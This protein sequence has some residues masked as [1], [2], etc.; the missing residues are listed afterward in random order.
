MDVVRQVL[1][2]FDLKNEVTKVDELIDGILGVSGVSS[3]QSLTAKE[4]WNLYNVSA[5]PDK[6]LAPLMR[7]FQD[8]ADEEYYK[9]TEP[10]VVLQPGESDLDYRPD[11]HTGLENVAFALQDVLL[12]GFGGQT[13]HVERLMRRLHEQPPEGE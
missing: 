9:D 6:F 3:T 4:F 12:E 10:W 13:G 2:Y 8:L 7:F 11:H 1:R 5:D